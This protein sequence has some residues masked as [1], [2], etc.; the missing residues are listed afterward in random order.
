MGQPAHPSGIRVNNMQVS[1]VAVGWLSHE[2]GFYAQPY[3]LAILYKALR[4][5]LGPGLLTPYLNPWESLDR[6]PQIRLRSRR[7]IHSRAGLAP[8]FPTFDWGNNRPKEL[9][10]L[11]SGRLHG[12]LVIRYYRRTPARLV[13]REA[14]VN[15][16]RPT[17]THRRARYAF[18]M[19]SRP[20]MLRVSGQVFCTL[21][22]LGAGE[23]TPRPPRPGRWYRHVPERGAWQKLSH[24][25]YRVRLG[26]LPVGG[27]EF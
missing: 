6:Y 19:W 8:A 24:A 3:L 25:A 7:I 9:E 21:K 20:R 10:R 17:I 4:L 27:G 18:T 11:G 12:P 23:R 15:L 1:D 26:R 14:G 2:P 22:G 13:L 5:W 16:M